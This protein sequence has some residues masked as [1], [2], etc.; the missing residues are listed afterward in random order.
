MLCHYTKALLSS[1]IASPCYNKNICF[2]S[3]ST[4]KQ[5]VLY[6]RSKMTAAVEEIHRAARR[7]V[8]PANILAIGTATP[9]N[10]ID[11][12]TYPDYYFRVTNSEHETELKNKFTRICE[13]STI[14]KRYTHLTEEILK[15]NPN[16]C[17]FTA[18]SLAARQQITAAEVP[19]LGREAAEKA[20]KEWGQPKS[21][22]THLVFCTTGGGVHM[23]G[24][25]CQLTKLLG[26]RPSVKRFMMYN[27]GCFAGAAALR[28]AKDLAENNSGA[29]VLVVCSEM[30]AMSFRGPSGTHMATLV[31]Q[32][33]FAD[34]AAAVVVGSD[35]AAGVERPL[36]Q[37]IST[38]QTLL[39]ESEGCIQGHL[40]D[41]GMMVELEKDVPELISK[42]IGASLS[43][44]FDPLGI[45]DW[46]SIFWGIRCYTW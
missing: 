1:L 13:K 25:D 31:E 3:S 17:A 4:R 46:N 2:P 26:L 36:F 18:P 40:T 39:P 32:S 37:I 43:E 34:G 9:A 24:C 28:M 16:M 35:A 42:Y 44:A 29:R 27:Q 19:R 21:M 6:C 33:L 20:I 10:C 30:T 38:A 7:A 12:S 41:C 11:Q 15:E 5:Q 8:G 14:K 23:P 45:S 22:I